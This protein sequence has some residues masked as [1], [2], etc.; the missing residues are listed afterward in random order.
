MALTEYEERVISELEE[1]LRQ[2]DSVRYER[3]ES[4]A[5]R[6]PRPRGRGIGRFAPPLACVVAGVAL[7]VAI[8]HAWFLVWMSNASGLPSSSITR[9][10]GVIG[11]VM[12]L[13]SAVMLR[14]RA[15][16]L[17]PDPR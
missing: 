8:R 15:R 2:D 7:L 6:V 12:V 16:D 11:C 9:A 5:A 13:G 1:Q 17:R 4:L 14:R 3:L 10:L